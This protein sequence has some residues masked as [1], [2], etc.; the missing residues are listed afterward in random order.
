[1]AGAPFGKSSM[2]VLFTGFFPRFSI[3]FVSELD[4]AERHIAQ[5]DEVFFTVCD[6]D[7]SICECNGPHELAY[8]ADCIGRRQD[9]I[10]LLSKPVRQLPL[11]SSEPIPQLIPKNLSTVDELKALKIENFDYGEAVYSSLIGHCL[12]T[13][14]DLRANFSRIEGMAADAYRVYQQAQKI[15]QTHKID[16]VYI[17][18]GRFSNPRAWVRACQKLGVPFYTHERSN[19]LGKIFRI[20]N[21]VIHDPTHY[22][23]RIQEFLE[24]S[25]EDAEA[26]RQG[27]EFFEERPKGKLSGWRSFVT[28]QNHEELPTGWDPSRRNISIF[29][30]TEREFVAVKQFTPK[31]LYESQVEAFLDIARRAAVADASIQFYLR[32]HPN[33]AQERVRWW[34]A[35]DFTSLSNLEVIPPESKVS[36]YA[37]LNAVEKTLCFRSS[38]GIEATYWGKPSIVLTWA[39]YGSL[40][41][42]YEPRSRDEALEFALARLEPKPRENAVKYGAFLRCGGDQLTY[43]KPIDPYSLS[44]KGVAL[45]VH[46]TVSRWTEEVT[47]RVPVQ[48]PKLVLR[49]LADQARWRWLSTMLKGRF[50]TPPRVQPAPRKTPARQ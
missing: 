6:A 34:E 46:P 47:K 17:F 40:D 33:S 35:P 9:G 3:H 27:T 14:P 48:G 50:A 43:A 26:I 11:L 30:S 20:E 12:S 39:F 15:L 13:E 44:F 16:R 4:Y 8:C 29:A 21:A 22:P 45:D 41:A 36:S 37:L 18:N 1:M 10:S 31:G 23:K 28:G 24:H 49:K 25:G 19:T 42:V 32:I 7:L 2:K 38:M 5:G